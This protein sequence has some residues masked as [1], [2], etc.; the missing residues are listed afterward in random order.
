MNYEC[1]KPDGSYVSIPSPIDKYV[2]Q[3]VISDTIKIIRTKPKNELP[4][5]M[6]SLDKLLPDIEYKK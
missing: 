6:N 2:K 3:R 5:K 4:E 1:D